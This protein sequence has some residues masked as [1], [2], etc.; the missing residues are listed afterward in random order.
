[1]TNPAPK[2]DSNVRLGD[3]GTRIKHF[4]IGRHSEYL[5]RNVQT[6]VLRI[7]TLLD[8]YLCGSAH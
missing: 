3:F 8:W 5:Q 6:E 2:S 4:R 7:E 1:M